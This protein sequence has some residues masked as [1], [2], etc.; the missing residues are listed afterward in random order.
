MG[1]RRKNRE[2]ERD[3][4]ACMFILGGLKTKPSTVRELT[5]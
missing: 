1:M 5:N 2:T 4:R 3:V